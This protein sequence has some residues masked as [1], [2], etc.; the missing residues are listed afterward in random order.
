[1]EGRELALHIGGIEGK[2][3][4]R[5][6]RRQRRRNGEEGVEGDTGGDDRDVIAQG[7]VLDARQHSLPAVSWDLS[8]MFGLAAAVGVAFPP[9]C[10]CDLARMLKSRIAIAAVPF[11]GHRNLLPPWAWRTGAR[12]W[13]ALSLAYVD[14][15]DYQA[16]YGFRSDDMKYVE[17]DDHWDR[18]AE[19]PQENTTHYRLLLARR[20][21]FALEVSEF[22]ST[23]GCLD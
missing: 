1:M 2:P 22:A 14:N 21:C 5:H 10:L 17:Q 7:P 16:A 4:E 12:P 13:A 11:R 19:C 18:N 23:P 9:R 6:Q 15:S 3:V 20:M 8:R